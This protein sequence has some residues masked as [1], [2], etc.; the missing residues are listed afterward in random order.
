M[1]E[2]IVEH[3]ID[4][5]QRALEL[6]PRDVRQRVMK[7]VSRTAGREALRRYRRTVISWSRKPH[8]EDVYE[9]TPDSATVLVGT[10]DPIYGYVDR[11]TRPHIIEPIGEGYP[12]RFQ[13][14]YRAKTMPGFL[15][16]GQGGPEGPTVRAMRVRHP[17]TKPRRFTEMIFSEVGKLS[18]ELLVK[19]VQ[20]QINK[21]AKWAARK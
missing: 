14:G 6:L 2:I 16:S 7:Q 10:D 17:G 12:L 18:W 21:R 20:Q 5:W 15:G 13:S 4:R 19:L 8:F 11:G 9:T 1:S 3:N